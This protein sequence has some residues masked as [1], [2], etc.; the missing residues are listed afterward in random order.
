MKRSLSF[1]CRSRT[2]TPL[3]LLCYHKK[4]HR[5]WW[6]LFVFSIFSCHFSRPPPPSPPHLVICASL[7]FL[8]LSSSHFSPQTF[9]ICL[10][11]TSYSFS[12]FS[13]ISQ[14]VSTFLCLRCLVLCPS[15][16]SILMFLF[17][18]CVLFN[19]LCLFQFPHGET[20]KSSPEIQHI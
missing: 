20:R 18:P 4:T 16:A 5:R 12:C 6:I 19:Y 14:C 11:P 7:F 8:V 3:L 9:L 2:G 1:C 13:V 15:N 10:S 17:S